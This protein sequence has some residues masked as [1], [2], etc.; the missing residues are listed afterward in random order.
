MR[1]KVRSE[2]FLL[3]NEVFYNYH[4]EPYFWPQTDVQPEERLGGEK[5]Q[6]VMDASTPVRDRIVR[7]GPLVNLPALLRELGHDPEPLF[8]A[9]GVGLDCYRDPDHKMP[10]L[11]SDRLLTVCTEATACDHIGLILG[12]MAEPSHLGMPGF[13]AHAA[14]TVEDALRALV[15]TLDLHDEGGTVQLHLEPDFSSLSY[16]VHLDGVSALEQIYDLCAVMMCKVMTLLC[17]PDWKPLTVRLGRSEPDDRTLYRRLFRGAIFFDSADCE[18]TFSNYCLQK[19]PPTADRLLFHHLQ[20]E[21]KVHHD[22]QHG[23]LTVTLPAVM[24]RCLLDGKF[25]AS[26]VAD[27]LGFHER[28]LHRRLNA[29]GTNFRHELDTVRRILSEQLLTHTGMAISDIATTLGYAD[30]SGF[31]RAFERWSGISPNAWRKHKLAP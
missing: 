7:V 24:R 3:R 15:E 12:Q 6:S 22:L 4:S 16:S 28:T 10:F 2:T 9:A 18:V 29:A 11:V 30:A 25:S 5:A 14:P 13:L 26:D 31:I 17:G 20:Q 27:A 19:T 1:E 8:A 21:A 23:E